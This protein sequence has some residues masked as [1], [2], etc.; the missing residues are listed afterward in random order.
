MKRTTVYDRNL[1]AKREV[2]VSAFHFLFSEI[3]QYC[4]AKANSDAQELERQL[5]ELG[6]PLGAKFLELVCFRDRNSKKDI[7]IIE[8]LRF[9]HG[10]LWKT[11]FNKNAD[12]L[13][14]NTEEHDTF[15]ISEKEPSL[16]NQF[17]CL[18]KG[19]D[20]LNCGAFVAGI[21]EGILASANFPAKVS[22][23]FKNDEESRKTV[24]LVKFNSDTIDG[25]Y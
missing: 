15:M 5:E 24:F 16:C 13:E 25:N 7:N 19:D 10:P 8:C 21:I 14:Q 12:E 23:I 2:S 9:I 17:A 18:P 20:Y 11:L 6:Q 3:V 22:A 4:L 1:K